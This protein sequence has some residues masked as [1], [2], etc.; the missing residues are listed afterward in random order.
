MYPY[1]SAMITPQL[2]ELQKNGDELQLQ[3]TW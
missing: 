1:Y 2:A 3:L